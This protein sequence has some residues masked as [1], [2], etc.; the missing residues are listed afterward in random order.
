LCILGLVSDGQDTSRLSAGYVVGPGDQIAFRV[1]NADEINDKPIPVDLSGYVRL[2]M[3]GRF[4]VAGLTV[5]QIEA[6]LTGRLNAYFLRPDVSVSIAEFRSQPVSVIGAVRNPGI[7]QVQGRK[8]LVEMLSLA[9]GLDPA[10]GSTLKITRQLEWGRIPLPS[11]VDD[12]TGQFSVAQVSLKSILEARAPEENIL[13]KPNDV[14]SVPKAENVYVIGQVQRAG[15][16][17]LREREDV[18][19]LQALSMAGGLERTAQPQHARILRRTPGAA[20]RTEIPVNLR[21]I[22]DGKASDV[23]LKAEDIVFVPSSLPK[24]A[25]IRALE[26]A[27]EIGTGVVIW[28]R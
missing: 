14:I 28:R 21:K 18:T 13:V 15:E 26:A 27:V 16:F 24:K 20:S 7:Q 1:V 5:A 22:L 19:I 10:A 4:R 9:G 25:A 11:A 6:E 8:T 3:V 12:T 23:S 17:V 2:P